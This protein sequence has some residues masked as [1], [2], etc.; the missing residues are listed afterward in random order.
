MNQAH[1]YDAL[2]QHAHPGGT[3]ALPPAGHGHLPPHMAMTHGHPAPGHPMAGPAPAPLTAHDFHSALSGLHREMAQMRDEH[4]H[5]RSNHHAAPYEARRADGEYDHRRG[6]REQER[7]HQERDLDRDHHEHP[8]VFHGKKRKF[9]VGF[10]VQT[11]IAAGQLQEIEVKP[12]VKFQGFRLAVSPSIARFF[13]IVDI[14][15][16][17]DSQLAATGEMP[18]EAFSALA[19]GALMELDQ[20]PPGI[21]ITLIVHNTDTNPQNFGAVLYGDVMEDN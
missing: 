17:K 9:P 20:A 1:D 18:A 8:H 7:H 13:N 12:Q 15:V 10:N 6:R 3:P 4:R 21:V 2:M 5:A 14:K 19:V 16:G 11:P